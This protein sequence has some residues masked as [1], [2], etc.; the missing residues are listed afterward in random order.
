MKHLDRREG[1]N[2]R[3]RSDDSGEGIVSAE[4]MSA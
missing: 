4:A 3:W 1:L 2:D